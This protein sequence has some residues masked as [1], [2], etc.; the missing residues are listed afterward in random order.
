[1]W[2]MTRSPLILAAVGAALALGA[3]GGSNDNGSGASNKS[4]GD[5]AFEGA[6]KFAKCMRDHGVDT[7][8][9]QRVGSGGIKM[10]MK[11][12]PGTDN[13]K[14]QAAQKDCQKYM[15]IGGGRA[16]SAAEKAKVQNSM[17]AYAKCMRQNGVNMPDPKFSSSGGGSTFQLGGPSKKGGTTG[18]N[19]DSPAFKKA[20]QACHGKLAD[21]GKGGPDGGP[22]LNSSGG[23]AG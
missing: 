6:L 22:A 15:K 4:Q 16:V 10:T 18:P 7:P 1:M 11:A 17:L 19:P 8:D 14:V 21:L 5:K 23:D 20:D 2:A 3:C 13:A 12:G 9:P